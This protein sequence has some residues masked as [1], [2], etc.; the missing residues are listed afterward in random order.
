MEFNGCELF[1]TTFAPCY[2]KSNPR[3]AFGEQSSFVLFQPYS[4]FLLHGVG[5]DTPHTVWHRPKTVRDR[6]RVNFK[7]AGRPYPIPPNPATFPIARSF[8]YPLDAMSGSVVEWWLLADPAEASVEPEE[9]LSKVANGCAHIYERVFE[10]N[11][12]GGCK[13]VR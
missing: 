12:R 9:S 7:L 11:S 5:S 8:V 1:V 3:F 10:S 4:S 6:I 2:D 13:R